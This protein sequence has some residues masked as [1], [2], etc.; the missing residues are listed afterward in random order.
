M[1]AISLGDTLYIE[2]A[3]SDQLTSTDPNLSCEETNL[4]YQA[5]ELFRKKT[6]FLFPISIHIQKQIP[7][8]SGLGGGSSNLATTLWALNLLTGKIANEKTL[9]E[10]AGTLSSDAPFFFSSGTAYCTGRGEKIRN[11]PPLHKPYFYLA[12]PAQGLSTSMVYHRCLP[13]TSSSE[14]PLKLL[15]SLKHIN[16]LEIPAFKLR[17]DLKNLKENL[18]SLGFETALMTGS[19]STFFCFGDIENPKLPGIK[20]TPASFF[21]RAENGWYDPP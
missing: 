8:S 3:D 9:Q 4:V 2:I 6:G 21:S 7:M 14:D 13:H 1:Q 15:A 18:L 17:A 20:F 11:L 10:W 12:S 5:V 16:D 19:G